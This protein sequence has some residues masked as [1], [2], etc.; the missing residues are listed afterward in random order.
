MYERRLK[1]MLL[2]RIGGQMTVLTT[3]QGP[4]SG[5]HMALGRSVPSTPWSSLFRVFV[6]DKQL[7]FSETDA[8]L[9]G[10]RRSLQR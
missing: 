7:L 6:K 5:Q 10:Q 4:V 3:R 9:S 8:Y 2:S 1:Q